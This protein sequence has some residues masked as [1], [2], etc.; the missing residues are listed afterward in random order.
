ML[1]AQRDSEVTAA[2]DGR[3]FEPV[4]QDHAHVFTRF[5]RMLL[6][7]QAD[8]DPVQGPSMSACSQTARYNAD[9]G[10]SVPEATD[11]RAAV[12]RSL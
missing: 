8:Y 5:L 12:D 4:E 6:I 10:R 2:M 11:P 1:R 3:F 7:R 9:R